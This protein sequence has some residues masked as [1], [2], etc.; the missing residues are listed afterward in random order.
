MREIAD[1]VHATCDLGEPDRRRTV[2]AP[3]LTDTDR[4]ALQREGSTP[5]REVTLVRPVFR[6]DP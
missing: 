1:Q 5:H 3:G 2:Y 6:S 4:E